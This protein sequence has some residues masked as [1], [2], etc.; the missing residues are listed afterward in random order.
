MIRCPKC[1][2][3]QVFD[4]RDE[5]PIGAE[6]WKRCLCGKRFDPTDPANTSVLTAI[7][8]ALAESKSDARKERTMGAWSEEAKERA[9]QRREARVGGKHADAGQA[10][11]ATTKRTR[12]VDRPKK[13]A[14]GGDCIA[15]AVLADLDE[16]IELLSTARDAV[17]KV[18]GLS[19]E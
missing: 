10:A 11:Q 1:H 14:G 13:A 2:G 6:E 16:R 19:E 8:Q 12:R 9:R 5:A 4:A 18:Y 3:T 7:E 17:R 15:A